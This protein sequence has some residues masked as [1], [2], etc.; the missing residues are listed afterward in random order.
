VP[1]IYL[2][3]GEASPNDIKL[4]DPTALLS[5]G[6]I[7]ETE[8]SCTG[9]ATVTGVASAI[10]NSL[11]RSDGV[12]TGTGIG[13]AIWDVAGS[14]TGVAVATGVGRAIWVVVGSSA[15]VAIVLADGD[16]ILVST[17]RRRFAMGWT[18]Q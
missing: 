2:Y 10:W 4:T 15:G 3:A 16:F 9:A 14:S 8:A 18:R 17:R 1:D 13:A 12:A 7:I 6:G 11:G 5:A